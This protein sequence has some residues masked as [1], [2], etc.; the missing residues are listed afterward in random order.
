M[1][2]FHYACRFLWNAATIF[3]FCLWLLAQGTCHAFAGNMPSAFA[4]VTKVV[5]GDTVTAVLEGGEE[6]QVRY[7]GIDTP[8][9]HHPS[10]E[11]EEFGHEAAAANAAFVL[12]KRVFLE[13]D[14]QG[15]DRYGRH[16]AWVWVYGPRGPVLV[17]AKLVQ[18]GYAMPF[19]LAPNVRHTERIIEAFREGRSRKR[20]FWGLVERRVF[21]A[22]Q[23]WAELPSLAGKFL[24]LE[25]IVD[26]IKKTDLRYSLVAPGGR[27]RFVVYRGDAPRFGGL[28]KLKGCSVR[29]AGKLVAGYQGAEMTL[30]DPVQILEIRHQRKT[31][32][33]TSIHIHVTGCPLDYPHIHT[34][35]PGFPA[36]STLLSGVSRETSVLH[37]SGT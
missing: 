33:S 31:H 12:G 36:L 21:S 20:G 5:D 34:S 30:A 15:L 27:V 24:T 25:F 9:L 6:V 19:T 18:L 29:A 37:I 26:K 10:R 35:F 13:R 1:K 4:F 22:S 8:E 3:V 14:V 28:E 7:L 32:S 2:G 16:L 23:A 11:R 17:N